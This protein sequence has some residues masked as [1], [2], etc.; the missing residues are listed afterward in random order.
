MLKEN[1]PEDGDV[2]M[3]EPDFALRKLLGPDLDLRKVFTPEKIKDCQ[4]IIDDARDEFF[5]DE[6]KKVLEIKKLVQLKDEKFFMQI[7]II[8]QD[9]KSQARLFGFG[10]I[11]NICSQIIFYAETDTKSLT[12]RLAIIS[13][14]VDA[15]DHAM[16]NRLKDETG[17]LEK[18]LM[19][20]VNS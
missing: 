15:L 11:A 2:T 3:E 6:I 13:K 16:K 19:S 14:F 10:F 9:L 17:Q 12:A 7:S 20:I 4:R 5:T 8:G 18:N 1:S